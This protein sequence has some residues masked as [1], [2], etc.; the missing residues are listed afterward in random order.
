MSFSDLNLKKPLL[1]AVK[2][3]G[4]NQPTAIQEKA[5]APVMSGKDVIGIAQTG[6]GKTVAYLLPALNMWKFSRDIFPQIIVIVPTR[7]LVV[8]VVDEAIRLTRYMNVIVQGVYGGAN[9]NT[10]A[11]AVENGLDLLVG[12]PGRVLDLVL[13]GSLKLKHVR[14]LVIDEVDETLSEGFRPQLMRIFDYLPEKRQNIMFSATLSEEVEEFVTAN[15]QAPVKI[16]AAPSGTPLENI[17]QSYYAVPNFTTKLN[18]LWELMQNAD[19]SKVLCFTSSRFMADE[20]FEHIQPLSGD[21][22]AVIHSNK[23]Q[24]TRFR[25]VNDFEAGKFRL[26]I[27]TDLIARG[28]DVDN[29]THVIN[30]DLPEN[31]EDYLHRI[32]RTGRQQRK[33]VAISFVTP[34]EMPKMEAIEAYLKMRPEQLNIPETVQISSETLE[35]EEDKFVI[36]EIRLKHD[37][38]GEGG[39]AFHEKA[40]KNK[41]VNV[42]YN[43][44]VAMQKKYGKAKTRGQKPR[45]KK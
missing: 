22:V 34:K 7:E 16:E 39:G 8:Q 12:T 17:Q 28:I 1:N 27:A 5:F 32:G 30:F 44:K 19:L 6:T 24:N 23:A 25:T 29:V 3:A 41:K 21:D 33:G 35:F 37:N 10:Q 13:R 43:H 26:L 31:E 45:G 4:Y 38:I 9:I 2:E 18:L 14:H 36:P 20:L 11:Q 42:R 15:F 40:D